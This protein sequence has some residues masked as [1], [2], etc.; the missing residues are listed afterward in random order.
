[1]DTSSDIPEGTRLG[2][3][4]R[5]GAVI[6]RGGMATVYRAHDE[7][8]DRPVAVKVLV[9]AAASPEALERQS[10]EARIG[11]QLSHPSLVAV[12]DVHNDETPPFLVMELV[13]GMTLSGAMERGR[14]KPEAV[15]EIG[16]QLCAGLAA[17]HDAGIV[18][19]DMKPSNVLLTD[20][21]ARTVK[22][23][24]FGISRL[25]DAARITS[26]GQLVGTARYL[27]PEQAAGQRVE[28]PTDVYAAG[29]VLL[30]CLTGEVAF[31]GSQVETL[32]ARL[33]RDPEIPES[34]GPDWVQVISAMT[35]REPQTRPTAV[36]AAGALRALAQGRTPPIIGTTP[37]PAT[38]AFATP[39]GGA[40][41]D[42]TAA[43]T[44]PTAP[45]A[46]ATAPA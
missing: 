26:T 1:M 37:D 39:V 5:L 42:S 24:D 12:Y 23:T 3:R 43:M 40:D 14:L 13:E 7:V 20:D 17:V 16:A 34:L 9:A 31:P 44:R 11:A 32:S 45:Q 22:L 2:G 28:R 18:H 46:A 41:S 36:E 8:L 29:L 27:S 33:H 10:S 15:A 25:V 38:A 19:R 30:E 35:A 21:T 4:Y 6:G